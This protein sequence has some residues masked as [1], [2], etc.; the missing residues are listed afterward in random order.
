MSSSMILAVEVQISW[1]MICES[2]ESSPPSPSPGCKSSSC[3]WSV[4]LV[5]L[6]IFHIVDVFV[7]FGVEV[8]MSFLYFLVVL[9]FVQLLFCDYRH[10]TK[11]TLQVHE[12]VHQLSWVSFTSD[13]KLLVLES[14]L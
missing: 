6:W 10:R 7:D 1:I 12:K 8:S 2:R 13:V 14:D 3:A 11:C 9:H 5:R 4:V